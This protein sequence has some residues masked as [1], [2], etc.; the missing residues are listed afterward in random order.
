MGQEQRF[1][2]VEDDPDVLTLMDRA[3]QA[4]G[5]RVEVFE[6]AGTALQA[7]SAGNDGISIVVTDVVLPDLSGPAMVRRMLSARPGLKVLFTTGYSDEVVANYLEGMPCTL[8]HKPFTIAELR[9]AIAVVLSEK[10]NGS[11]AG[12]GLG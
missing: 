8:L 12:A 6:D 7:F 11:E 3:L 10:D 2:V 5:R 9:S 1:L 4:P